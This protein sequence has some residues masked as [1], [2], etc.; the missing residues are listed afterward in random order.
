MP[1]ASL[2]SSA[3]AQGSG[4]GNGVAGPRLRASPATSAAPRRAAPRAAV[5]AVGNPA[6]ADWIRLG[7]A[8]SLRAPRGR[9]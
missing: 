2:S 4:S 3:G 5:A 7:I 9:L 6:P 1:G 8:A